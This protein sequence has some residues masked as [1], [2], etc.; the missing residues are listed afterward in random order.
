MWF[1][2]ISLLPAVVCCS[3]HTFLFIL[4][5]LLL[6]SFLSV[7]CLHPAAFISHLFWAHAIS[8]QVFLKSLICILFISGLFQ[9]IYI[10]SLFFIPSKRPGTTIICVLFTAFVSFCVH[11]VS[12]C[13]S[14]G[15]SL[16]FQSGFWSLCAQSSFWIFFCISLVIYSTC[17]RH[18]VS[19]T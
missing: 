1:F 12:T 11:L 18:F 19:F 4:F 6:I 17:L 15:T 14:V 7:V 5:C 2:C 9:L 8:V 16:F 3:L 10:S 13:L